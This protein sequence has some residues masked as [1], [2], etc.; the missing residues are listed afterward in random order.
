MTKSKD[1][2]LNLSAMEIVL[3]SGPPEWAGKVITSS[4]TPAACTMGATFSGTQYVTVPWE[5]R[6]LIRL[7]A[8]RL[9]M[10]S[11]AQFVPLINRLCGSGRR[12]L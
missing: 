8:G 2:F 7:A 1:L 6:L 12:G 5:K 11:P 4:Q 10:V 3:R 9:M